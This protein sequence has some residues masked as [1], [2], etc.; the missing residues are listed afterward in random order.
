LHRDLKPENVFVSRSGQVKIADFGTARLL[1]DV[2]GERGFGIGT[3]AYMA[4]E[5]LIDD[6]P[7]FPEDG[8]SDLYSLGI[9]EYEMVAGYNPVLGEHKQLS[10]AEVSWRQAAVPPRVPVGVPLELW[11]VLEPTLRKEPDRRP[12]SVRDHLHQLQKVTARLAGQKGALPAAWAFAPA[13]TPTELMIRR[14][15]RSVVTGAAVGAAGGVL[16][17]IGWWIGAHQVGAARQAPERRIAA[18]TPHPAGAPAPADSE[19]SGRE[20]PKGSHRE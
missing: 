12:S 20:A 3:P 1:A 6:G 10:R 9:I 5:R 15:L 2:H 14:A 8:R 17:F 19:T 13:R 4:P 11:S 16:V 18:T 7:A